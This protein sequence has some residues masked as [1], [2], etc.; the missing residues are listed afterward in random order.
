MSDVRAS[1][2]RS[3]T[4]NTIWNFLGVAA[5]VPAALVAIPLLIAGLG[6]ERFGLLTI[7]WAVMGYFSVFDFGLSRATTGFLAQACHDGDE[8]A[9]RQL[10]W[11]STAAHL[12]LGV[13]GGVLLALAAPFL[14]RVLDIAP[15]LRAET[16]TV[17][18]LLALSVPILLLTSVT[19]GVLEAVHRFDLVNA[20]KLPASLI[21]YLGP[22]AALAFTDRLPPVVLVIL[23]ARMGVLVSYVAMCTRVLP[24]VR[25]FRAPRVLDLRPLAALGGWITVGTVLA[26]VMVSIDRFVIGS[27]VSVAAVVAYAAPYEVVTKLW[28]FSASLLGVL[29]PRFAILATDPAELRELYWRALLWLGLCT[30][31]V[32]VLMVAFAPEFFRAWLGAEIAAQGVV[33][34]QWLT[35]GVLINVLAQVPYTVLQAT[36][37]A[38]AAG[39]LQLFEL[40]LYAVVIWMAAAQWG[41]AGVAIGWTVRAAADAILMFGAVWMRLD[42]MPST[43]VL[44]KVGLVVCAATLLIVW[45]WQVVPLFASALVPKAVLVGV[46]VATFTYFASRGLDLRLMRTALSLKG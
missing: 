17:F 7:A 3:I 30:T 42:F 16:A 45:C 18:A 31:P 20:V 28:M 15:S 39:K 19:R 9:A 29:F 46:G 13:A 1:T 12:S 43:P 24:A 8:E 4:R 41:V 2:G 5:P 23:V 14:G 40:P 32:A 35:I 21:T 27:V 11:S 6:Q 10:F 44:L 26:P 22:L 37:H 36:G 38:D 33:V 25:T 34:A